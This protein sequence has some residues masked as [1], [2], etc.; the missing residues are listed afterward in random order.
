MQKPN[1]KIIKKFIAEKYKIS[2]IL[3]KCDQVS[4]DVENKLK[5]DLQNEISGLSVISVCSEEKA[6]RTGITKPF[7]KNDVERQAFE[8]FFD[9][10]ILRLPLRCRSVMEKTL[11]VWVRQSN[12][13]AEDNAGFAGI[14][15]SDVI[16]EIKKSAEQFQLLMHDLV[17]IEIKQTFKMYG[18]FATHLGYPPSELN[19]SKKIIDRQV[20]DVTNMLQ[21]LKLKVTNQ[22]LL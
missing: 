22:E 1:I 12:R 14:H 3:T 5:N 13:K 18:T 16:T 4:E 6:T 19:D 9:S 17:N 10:L 2:V 15:E 11:D 7:G 8:D 20:S 21:S